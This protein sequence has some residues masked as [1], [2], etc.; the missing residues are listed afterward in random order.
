MFGVG[1]VA[2]DGIG[3]GVIAYNN[4]KPKNVPVNKSNSSPGESDL[5][6]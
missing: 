1:L 6:K 3:A 2:V 5:E 4:R